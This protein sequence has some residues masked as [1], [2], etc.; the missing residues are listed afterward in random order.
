MVIPIRATSLLLMTLAFIQ[1]ASSQTPMD[2][3]ITVAHPGFSLLKSDLKTTIDLTSP[4]EQKQ[5]ENIQ[6]YIDTFII[7]IDETREVQVQ[8]LT[9]VN[10]VGYLICVPLVK[11]ADPSKEFREN[12]DSLDYRTTRDPANHTLYSFESEALEYGWMRVDPALR[13]A[14]LTITKNKALVPTLKEIVLKAAL[15]PTKLNENMIAELKNTD[16]TAPAIT[17]RIAAFKPIRD[18]Q[19]AL[20]KQRPDEKPTAFQLRQAGARQLYDEAQRI[21][22]EAD[23]L[24]VTLTMDRT[25]PA[26][27]KFNLRTTASAIPG[28][29]MEATI[30]QYSGLTDAFAGLQRI[31]GS[32]LSVR[33]NHPLDQLRQKHLTETLTLTKAD[34]EA[35]ITANKTRTDVEKKAFMKFT[36]GVFGVLESSIKSGHLNGMIESIPDKNEHFT[37]IAVF[38]SPTAT[39]LNQI[40][41]LLTEAGKGN[42][43]AM[44]A[45]KVGDVDIHKIQIAEGFIDAFDK[46]FGSH[47]DLYIGVGPQRVW[48]ASGKNG[49]ET[50][51]TTIAAV[52]AAAPNPVV[53]KIEGNLLPWA[54]RID[55]VAKK[56]KPAKLTADE[57]KLRREHARVRERALAAFATDDD[58]SLIISSDA[59]TW[60]GEFNSNTGLL[61]FAGKMMSAFSKENFE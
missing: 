13:Y 53:L 55:A 14:F 16:T 35:G 44:N 52:G 40:L 51:K 27:P 34:I 3:R 22:S 43:V 30:A 20:I 59:G 54:K 58:F 26:A 4:V 25:A 56:E 7:G 31:E 37:T 39:E 8:V 10:P 21:M 18:E 47:E 6:G 15:V 61:R 46:I 33:V 5:W 23:Q 50:L 28:T 41:P 48:M 60:V 12:L 57:E 9:G 17:H 1:T 45:E 24:L 29:S 49:L 11:G 38:V 36:T 2:S 19:M 32:A 42:A